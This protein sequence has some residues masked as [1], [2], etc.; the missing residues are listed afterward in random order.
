MELLKC[1]KNAE[2]L[3][4]ISADG[5]KSEKIP[6]GEKILFLVLLLTLHRVGRG[7]VESSRRRWIME[8]EFS[9]NINN[10][11]FSHYYEILTSVHSEKQ[12]DLC[13]VL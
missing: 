10:G 1:A 5:K 2:K 12:P 9:Y 4:I 8:E 11:Y 13:T 7:Y 3:E 6:R